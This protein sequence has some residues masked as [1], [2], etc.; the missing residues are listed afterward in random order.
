MRLFKILANLDR[1][2]D[3]LSNLDDK[4]RLPVEQAYAALSKA[5]ALSAAAGLNMETRELPASIQKALKSVGYGRRDIKVSTS[6]RFS[7]QSGG[8]DGKKSFSCLV[9]LDTGL[10]KTEMGSWGGGNMFNQ[11]LSDDDATVRPLPPGIAVILGSMGGGQPTYATITVHP[12][13]LAPLLPQKTGD[14][15]TDDE[16]KALD[17]IGGLISSA[18]KTTFD[19][20]GLGNYSAANPIIVSLAAKG[21][22]KT[23]AN[24]AVAITTAGKNARSGRSY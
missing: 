4:V 19:R 1:V 11:T 15:P 20:E 10:F 12:S 9:N 17:I 8:A 2:A 21:L 7:L 3:R 16:V 24:G 22:V 13:T 23:T 6:T 18:R 14:G 5:A